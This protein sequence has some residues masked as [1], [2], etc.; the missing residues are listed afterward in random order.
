MDISA[1][2]FKK[3]LETFHSELE[4]VANKYIPQG[5][6]SKLLHLSSLP[7]TIRGYVS[8]SHGLGWEYQSADRT[9][10]NVL[11]GNSRIENVLI[12]APER[13]E[14]SNETA[15]V[16]ISV[17]APNFEMVG[18]GTFQWKETQFPLRLDSA[19]A[20]CRII[21][22]IFHAGA[23]RR[24]IHHA[25]MYANR[26]PSEWS[27]EKAVARANEQVLAALYD[28]RQADLRRLPLDKYIA[29]LKEKMV[30]VLG[31][32]SEEVRL[33]SI[34]DALE[35][36]GYD[37]VLLRD[38]PDHPYQSLRQHAT[39]MAGIS[40][41]IVIEDSSAS[42]HLIELETCR[43]N[44][45]VTVI[46]REHGRRSSWMTA[47]DS[48]SSNLILEREYKADGLRQIMVEATQW[49]EKRLQQLE[50][51]LTIYPWR[52]AQ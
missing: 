1:K 27:G 33:K 44:Q 7:A 35:S 11:T 45:W 15:L 5:V 28:L 26:S 32:Y 24:Q 20:S 39:V 40:R 50:K 49:A 34:C 43:F 22:V 8:T 37:P 30:L 19:D 47:G 31:D 10:V 38:I 3:Y 51:Q 25:E 29:Q 41:F 2:Q 23:W 16:G 52:P 14:L 42:G 9:R 4:R 6:R 36:I 48:G 17:A 21:G 18:A 12:A 13:Y 46:L